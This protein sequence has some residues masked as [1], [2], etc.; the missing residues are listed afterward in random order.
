MMD[1]NYHER[2]PFTALFDPLTV[3]SRSNE[4]GQTWGLFIARN[5]RYVSL[6]V[7][8]ILVVNCVALTFAMV[9]DLLFQHLLRTHSPLAIRS[10]YVRESFG[11]GVLLEL[12][13]LLQFTAYSVT[14]I[15]IFSSLFPP[16]RAVYIY[17]QRHKKIFIFIILFYFLL[18][19]INYAKLCDTPPRAPLSVFFF[20]SFLWGILVSR[21]DFSFP[22]YHKFFQGIYIY[23]YVRR[24]FFF[25]D[26][27]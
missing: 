14:Y 27:T 3:P 5:R 22:F 21:I 26:N 8:L 7:G 1:Q 4:K 12:C 24:L 16:V 9:R 17:T 15:H 6:I 2:T 20:S 25:F 23:M 11:L 18:F 19:L 13:L 10:T